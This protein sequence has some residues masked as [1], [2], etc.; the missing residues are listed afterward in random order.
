MNTLTAILTLSI[1]ILSL[2]EHRESIS[3]PM[4]KQ[5]FLISDQTKTARP[6]IDLMQETVWLRD[7]TIYKRKTSS[8][9][10]KFEP[11]IGFDDF[12]VAFVDNKKY[13]DI[14]HKSNKNANKFRTIV[15][16]AYRA[17]KAN[18]GGHYTFVY[19]GCGSSCQSS[20]LVDRKTGKIYDSPGASLG[21]DFRADSKMLIVNPPDSN[22]FYDDC[23]YCK[24]VIYLFDDQSKT[25]KKKE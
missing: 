12:K 19:W 10:I 14:D 24:P 1:L 17:D 3:Y 16:E 21:Y 9:S 23:T 6:T 11:S 25:F 7:T 4:I 15:R 13:A 5:G 2:K 18:F 20:F 22:G 8:S